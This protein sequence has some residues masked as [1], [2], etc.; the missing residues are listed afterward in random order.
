VAPWHHVSIRLQPLAQQVWRQHPTV[1]QFFAQSDN[2]SSG[3]LFATIGAGSDQNNGASCDGQ[4]KA[5][6][7]RTLDVTAPPASSQEFGRLRYPKVLEDTIIDDLFR[8]TDHFST[9]YRWGVRVDYEC[10]PDADE[11]EVNS[12]SFAAG[13]LKAVSLPLPDYPSTHSSFCP[14]CRYP[15]WAMPLPDTFFK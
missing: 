15:G 1:G 5:D 9:L 12:N 10:F 3:L 6:I 14:L 2:L 7:N 13:L 8:A 11:A 4:L